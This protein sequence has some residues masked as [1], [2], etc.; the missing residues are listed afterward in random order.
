MPPRAPPDNLSAARAAAQP[1]AAVSA[2][3]VNFPKFP[4]SVKLGVA[5][6]AA[7]ALGDAACP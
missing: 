5:G 4:F 1:G 2:P 3:G 7:G 6:R